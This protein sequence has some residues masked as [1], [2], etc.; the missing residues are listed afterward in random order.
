[1]LDG[2][3]PVNP[4]ASVIQLSGALNETNTPDKPERIV[5]AERPWVHGLS[6]GAATYTFPPH[7]FTMILFDWQNDD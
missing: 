4:A 5:P 6:Q 7:S 1:V 3:N 2:F